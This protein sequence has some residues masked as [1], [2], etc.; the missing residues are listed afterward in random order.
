M[1]QFYTAFLFLLGAMVGAIAQPANDT[2]CTAVPIVL[3]APAIQGTFVDA[4]PDGPNINCAIPS[5]LGVPI[6]DVWYSFVAPAVGAVIIETQA[7]TNNDTQLQLI[8]TTPASTCTGTRT[9]VSCNDD[10]SG[11]NFLS[12]ITATGLTPGETYYV[13]VDPWGNGNGTF[14][15]FINSV[16]SDDLRLNAVYSAGKVLRNQA[17]S[18]AIRV[19]NIGSA[20]SSGKFARFRV[21]GANPRALD[22]IAVP[23]ISSGS[24]VRLNLINSFTPSNLGFDTI[25]ITLSN[26][27]NNANNS[28]TWVMEVTNDRQRLAADG[29]NEVNG[30]VWT[31]GGGAGPGTGSWAIKYRSTT[32]R[33]IT[34]VRA[35]VR[36]TTTAVGE[37]ITGIVYN[38]NGTIAGESNPRVI[39]AADLGTYVEMFVPNTPQVGPGVYFIGVKQ[40]AGTN[41]WGGGPGQNEDPNRDSTFY[42]VGGGGSALD[43]AGDLFDEGIRLMVEAVSCDPTTPVA[44]TNF[45]LAAPATPTRVVL[46]G[47]GSQNINFRWTRSN[48]PGGNA[49][50]YRFKADVD[51]GT[52]PDFTNPLIEEF[53]NNDGLDT[54]F[55][56][57]YQD[58]LDLVLALQADSLDMF[59]IAEARSCATRKLAQDTFKIR[60]VPGNLV[61]TLCTPNNTANN[62][63]FINIFNMGQ[64][65]KTTGRNTPTQYLD[66]S[67]TDSTAHNPGNPIPFS[68]RMNASPFSYFG[69]VMVDWNNNNRFDSLGEGYYTPTVLDS[70]NGALLVGSVTIPTGTP[71]NT[72]YRMRVIGGDNSGLVRPCEVTFGDVEDY[73]LRVGTTG[74]SIEA[75]ESGID[76]FPNPSKGKVQLHVDLDKSSLLQ[77]KLVNA[78][79]AEL[80]TKSFGVVS[81]EQ[82]DLDLSNLSPGI[83]FAR[84]LVNDQVINKKLVIE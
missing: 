7:G 41:I 13:Q 48:N 47:A 79:G 52:P 5:D 72:S 31:V 34:N 46:Q 35:F 39:T 80:M 40:I 8:R 36:N 30:F 55:A 84:I 54:S 62:V 27:Q 58:A 49:P 6:R 28:T 16:V 38:A 20:A 42:A 23:A 44:L 57:S 77:F 64:I 51:F 9:V 63:D 82:I 26:D 70:V 2:I 1:K 12:R 29:P 45:N 11:S 4:T 18:L 53:S 32:P 59:W 74:I 61:Y 67:S 15:I 17:Q 25:I 78:V 37:A 83:Y 22:S 24:G 75:I 66:F 68:I 65:N 76:L 21:N 69:A 43:P 33:I 3:N 19:N 56:L 50:S 60:L 14:F 81:Q 71:I 10:I 73:R